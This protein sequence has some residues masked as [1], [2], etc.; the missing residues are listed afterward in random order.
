MTLGTDL[1]RYLATLTLSGG[2]HDGSQFVVLGW[3]RRFLQG[4]FR[5]PGDAALSV[6][7]GNGK[8]ALVAGLATATVGP[9]RAVAWQPARSD[10]V[11]QVLRAGPPGLR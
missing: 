2:D 9:A 5:V 10:C 8:S 3:E 1:V 6:G 7:R 11:R 4:A